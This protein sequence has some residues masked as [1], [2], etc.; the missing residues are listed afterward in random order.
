LL[1]LNLP[2]K[3]LV[4]KKSWL[5]VYNYEI[6]SWLKIVTDWAFWV[7]WS[8]SL[9]LYCILLFQ[10]LKSV[11]PRKPSVAPILSFI[12]AGYILRYFRDGAKLGMKCAG[13]R[14]EKQ[15][16]KIVATGVVF[17]VTST[18]TVH[19]ILK[20]RWWFVGMV[21]WWLATQLFYAGVYA[22]YCRF[23]DPTVQAM[24]SL[25]RGH[26]WKNGRRS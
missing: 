25:L 26:S 10:Y 18:A 14:P 17:G 4:R 11:D 24:R 22:L 15:A 8:S 6:V 16:V 20:D 5:K 1:Y 21:A 23:N 13:F 9:S 3:G 2:N 12:A 7:M 19:L